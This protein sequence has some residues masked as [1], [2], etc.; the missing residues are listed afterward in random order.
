MQ[1]MKKRGS[2]KIE[3]KGKE[4]RRMKKYF[5]KWNKLENKSG[6]F[7]DYY[8]KI[9]YEKTQRKI[10]RKLQKR[11][12]KLKGKIGSQL[13]REESK[14]KTVSQREDRE[15]KDR[16]LRK[17][18]RL[19]NESKSNMEY[20]PMSMKKKQRNSKHRTKRVKEK[21][22]KQLL[23]YKRMMERKLRILTGKATAGNES[24]SDD[25]YGFEA[26]Q[27]ENDITRKIAIRED[28]EELQRKKAAK[29]RKKK[30]N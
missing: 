12:Q 22:N 14:E 15:R 1:K 30:N 19:R 13:T 25:G 5:K 4:L 20:N 9:M 8:Q 10:Q 11:E 24:D 16:V 17:R 26:L 28:Y 29:K 3:N 7:I 2:K 6:E 18:S 21:P 23:K 27:R